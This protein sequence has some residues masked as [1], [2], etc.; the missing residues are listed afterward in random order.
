MWPPSSD[1]NP[2]NFCALPLLKTKVCASDDVLEKSLTICR[3]EAVI[4]TRGWEE[5]GGTLKN[6]VS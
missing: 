1:L 6:N 3:L 5:L 4:R 2:M